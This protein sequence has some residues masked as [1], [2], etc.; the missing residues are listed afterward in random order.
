MTGKNTSVLNRV[1]Y[2]ISDAEVQFATRYSP[3]KSVAI[4]VTTQD[5]KALR[6]LYDQAGG[7]PIEKP[8]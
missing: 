7:Q 8:S 6:R 2:L 3:R 4:I 5:V 1:A